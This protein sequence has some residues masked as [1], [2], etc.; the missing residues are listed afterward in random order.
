MKAEDHAI[1]ITN[2]PLALMNK[3]QAATNSEASE[4]QLF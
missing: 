4:R 1:Y 3:A 2:E